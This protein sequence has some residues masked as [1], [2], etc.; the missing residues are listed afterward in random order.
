MSIKI[1]YFRPP[2]KSY[3]L[4][5]FFH[6][7]RYAWIEGTTKS[8]KT[9]AGISWFLEEAHIG[10]FKNYWWVAPT[11]PTAR[12]AFTRICDALAPETRVPNKSDASITL[13]NGH[14]LWF[15]SG[16][17]PDTLY[18]EDVGAVVLDENS[19]MREAA[20]WAIRTT[21]TF[22]RAKIRGIGNIKG[23]KNWAYRMAR[24]AQANLN[25]PDSD[26]HW[27]A[28]TSADAVR[29][30][31]LQQDEIDDAQRNLP[32]AVFKELYLGIPSED[33]SN[34]FGLKSIEDCVSPLSNKPARVFGIDLAKGKLPGGD[35]TV[36]CGLDANG[37]LC[38][39]DRW[40]APWT[41]TKERIK[42]MVG[43]TKTLVDSTGVGDPVLEDLQRARG[44]VFEGYTFSQA[45]KQKLMEGLAIAIQQQKVHFPDGVV[46]NELESFEYEYIGHDGRSTGV[47]YS[48][49][50]GMYDD[51]VC[52][53]ALAVEMMP[54]AVSLWD[55]L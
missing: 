46:R 8:G 54:N 2:L 44:G 25:N 17:D 48:A 49:P 22:T 37:Y 40:Q 4:S 15:K 38:K 14:V 9:H 29:E 43:N 21:T 30:G 34:P 18:G 41:E 31:I 36:V 19:R 45:S 12:I 16:E 13:L 1:E 7:K 33:G 5:A 51:C 24:K 26:S 6:D 32:D 3:Q 10:K 47:R 20:W 28:I 55:R 27:A 35:W 42:S 50:G 23:T 39:F 11:Y 52:S 53:L